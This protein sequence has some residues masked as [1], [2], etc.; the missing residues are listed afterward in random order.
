MKSIENVMMDNTIV[1]TFSITKCEYELYLDLFQK[2]TM[3]LLIKYQAYKIMTVAW[4]SSSL[5]YCY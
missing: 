2:V 4:N 1:T 3:L 5:Y